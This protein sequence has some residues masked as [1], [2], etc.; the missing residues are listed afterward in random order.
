MACTSGCYGLLNVPAHEA[1]LVRPA[2]RR[3]PARGALEHFDANL[4]D[5]IEE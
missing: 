3:A 4:P 2:T 5:T 1:E